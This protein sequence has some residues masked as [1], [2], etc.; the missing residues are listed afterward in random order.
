[1]VEYHE[2][3]KLGKGSAFV[4]SKLRYLPQTDDVWEVDFQ[5]IPPQV[6]K[7]VNQGELWLGL[8]VSVPQRFHLANVLL[9]VPPPTVNDL[10]RVL[11]QAMNRP[12]IDHAHRPASV[13]PRDNPQ[14]RE[15]LPHLAQLGIEV[16]TQDTL[17]IWDEMAM[18]FF[19]GMRHFQVEHGMGL[20]T[21]PIDI[22]ETYPTLAHW[23]QAHGRVEIG[24]EHGSGVMVRAFDENGVVFESTEPENLAEALVALE[25]GIA[26]VSQVAKRP[27]V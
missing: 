27:I 6:C 21:L 2:P 3:L 15:L 4:K 11:A 10:G 22:D 24:V 20:I 1:M 18:E 7:R 16:V 12:L 25:Q 26:E 23:V 13:H 17:P 9:E 14:W 8:V 19:R 5:P